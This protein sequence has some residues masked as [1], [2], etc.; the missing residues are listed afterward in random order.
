MFTGV[1]DSAQIKLN[2]LPNWGLYSV[3]RKEQVILLDYI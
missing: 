3:K 2:V 1:F